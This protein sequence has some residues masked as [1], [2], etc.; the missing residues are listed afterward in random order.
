MKTRCLNPNSVN[1]KDYGGRGIEVCD[2]W[3]A[4]ENFI[5]DVG[6]RPSPKHSLDRYPDK[7]G[8]YEPGNVRW[9]LPEEQQNNRRNTVLVTIDGKA[10]PLAEVCR[11]RGLRLRSIWARIDRGWTPEK[12]VSVPIRSRQGN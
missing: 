2:R 9:A 6:P 4:F 11:D 3:L 10:T 7:N 1:F 5:A 8:N 12:A